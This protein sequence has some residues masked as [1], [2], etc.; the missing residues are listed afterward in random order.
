M[1]EIQ[2]ANRAQYQAPS[3]PAQE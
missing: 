3:Q 1:I 2:A